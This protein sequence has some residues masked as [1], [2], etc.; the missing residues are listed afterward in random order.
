M[1]GD[2]YTSYS[3]LMLK[4]YILDKSRCTYSDGS[5]A[6]F[7]ISFSKRTIVRL[8]LLLNVVDQD[9]SACSIY[10]INN[11]FRCIDT[12]LIQIGDDDILSFEDRDNSGHV[13]TYDKMC[14]NLRIS[15]CDRSSKCKDGMLRHLH[16]IGRL[17]IIVFQGKIKSN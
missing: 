4:R 11:A 8:K 17:E 10:E 12:D 9:T 15:I 13:V 5:L 7:N 1:N 16:T 2:G 3:N 14:N 6:L